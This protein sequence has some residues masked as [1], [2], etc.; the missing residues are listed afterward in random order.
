M[1]A[2]ALA[3][4]AVAVVATGLV[5]F[6]WPQGGGGAG[7]LPYEDAQAVERGRVLYG[8]HCAACHGPELQGE[9]DWQV[10]DAEGYLPAPPHDASGH[11]WHHDDRLLIRLTLQGTAAVIGG[12]YRSRMPGFEDVLSE[13]QVREVLAFIK[14]TW[15]DEI[16]QRHNALNAGAPEQGR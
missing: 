11:S 2:G 3:G 5:W 7:L 10:P 14:S 6:Q 4:M 12:G 8:E 16:I 13:A 15:P 1:Q 9:P